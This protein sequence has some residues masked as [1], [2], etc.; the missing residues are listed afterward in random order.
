[1][2]CASGRELVA[3][4]YR[5]DVQ[6]AAEADLGEQVPLLVDGCFASAR[7]NLTGDTCAVVTSDAGDTG[8]LRRSLGSRCVGFARSALTVAIA[9]G[10]VRVVFLHGG[11]RSGRAAWPVQAAAISDGCVFMERF[12]DRD[13]PQADARRVLSALGPCGDLVAHSSG[14][15]AAILAAGRSSAQVRTLILCEPACVSVARGSPRVEE[16]VNALA[17]VFRPGERHHSV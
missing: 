6:I 14:A 7:S 2:A 13:D 1:M 15:L 12:G 3:K 4:G 5:S 16:H 9:S 10:A 17:P 11:G 8:D